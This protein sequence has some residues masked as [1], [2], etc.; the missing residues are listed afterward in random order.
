MKFNG[1]ALLL[2]VPIWLLLVASGCLKSKAH[3][4]EPPTVIRVVDGDTIKIKVD[5]PHPL[6]KVLNLRINQI[7][8]PEKGHRA[9]CSKERVLAA[10][11]TRFSH[12]L[13]RKAKRVEVRISKW[14]KYGGRVLGDIALDGV[15]LSDLLLA[16]GL[17]MPYRGKGPKHDWCAD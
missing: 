13:I 5:L 17:A 10:K 2:L 12:D 8:T 4:I 1:M 6:P 7:D 14:G 9:K 15:Y 3:E 11:A 16:E